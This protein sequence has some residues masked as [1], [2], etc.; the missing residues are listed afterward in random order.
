MSDINKISASYRGDIDSSPESHPLHPFLPEHARLLMCGT[1][2]PQQHRWSMNFYYPNFINDMWRIFGIV[3]HNDKDYFVDT[4]SR[5]FRQSI[6]KSELTEHGIAL[7]DTGREVVRTADN[8]S[9]KFLDIRKTIDLPAILAE[10]PEC[11]DIAT[12]GEKAAS[13]IAA[14]T[15]SKSPAMGKYEEC[16]ITDTTGCERTLRHWR[17]PSSSRAYPMRLENKADYYRKMLESI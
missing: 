10:I 14:I 8:A 12:T 17:M 2:P 7:S 11:T 3:W 1:F 13:V 4:E 16:R 5:T 15:E 9:D 6:L